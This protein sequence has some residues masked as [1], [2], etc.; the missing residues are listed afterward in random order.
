MELTQKSKKISVFTL[1]MINVIAI[2]SLRSI[3]INAQYGSSLIFYYIIAA[4]FFFI[5]SALVAAELASTWPERGG[6]YVWIKEAF[7]VRAGFLVVWLQ[8]IYNICWYPTILS[9]LAATLAY[10]IAPNLIDNKYYTL[11]IILFSYWLTTYINCRGIKSSGL[12]SIISALVGTILP[13]LFIISLGIIWWYGDN[14]TQINFTHTHLIPD[15]KHRDTLIL[16]S[17]ILYGLVGIEMSAYHAQDVKNPARDYPKALL[18]STV[19]ILITS[20]GSAL[21]VSSVVPKAILR[22]SLVD[23]LFEAFIYFFA[24]FHIL[25]MKPIIATL[26]II[27]I[28]GGVGAWIIGPSK[29]M[30]VTTED[31]K[32]PKFLTRINKNGAP[33]GVLLLQGLIFTVISCVYLLMP[34]VNS[35]FFFLSNLT[36]QLSLVGYIFMFLAALKLR[37]LYPNKPRAYKIPGGKLGITIVTLA[38]STISFLA[39]MLTFLPP[40]EIVVGSLVKYFAMLIGGFIIL[41]LPPLL[42]RLHAAR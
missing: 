42:L 18:Y 13:M 32:L 9:F 27:G 17:S 24:K 30:L 10:V 14:P 22:K 26:I 19:L 11:G 31:I 37:K 3:A 35:A 38:G 39:I 40:Q 36:A 41:L 33:T 5:P 1:V 6:I 8:W 28:I 21:A 4:L 29:G 23:A 12:L 16:F 7:G 20:I 25:W 2:D 15:F 34:T